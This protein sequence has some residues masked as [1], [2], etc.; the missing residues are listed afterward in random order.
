MI[1]GRHSK[2]RLRHNIAAVADI[3]RNTGNTTRH[4]LAYGVRKP[5]CPGCRAGKIERRGDPG[6]VRAFAKKKSATLQL[7]FAEQLCNLRLVLAHTP[8]SKKKPHLRMRVGHHGSSLKKI[9]VVFHGI[10]S[11]NQANKNR[12]LGNAQ[13]GAYLPAGRIIRTED[14]AIEAVGND[15]AFFSL[16]TDCLVVPCSGLA[17][18]DDGP[19]TRGKKSTEPNRSTAQQGLRAV[20]VK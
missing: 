7:M 12:F 11:G 14:L 3:C 19:R 1:T 10:K 20:V 17:V 9:A 8:S 5:L 4:R 6:H 16:V 15:D 18:V 13:L 2:T